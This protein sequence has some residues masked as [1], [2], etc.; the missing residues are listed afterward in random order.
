MRSFFAASTLA[1]LAGVA[2]AR[3][4]L[5]NEN[6]L[7]EVPPG[8]KIDFQQ[9][10][11]SGVMN[12]MV[13]TG[14]T[15]NDWTEMVTVQIFYNMKATPPQFLG[16]MASTWAAAC[17]GAST[18]A[19]ASGPE[20]GYPAGVS[21][22]N[23]PKNP[24]TGKPELTWIKAVQGNDSFYVVQKAFKFTPSKDEVVQWM[25]YLRSVAV[26]DSRLADRACP[27]TKD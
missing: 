23:C 25:K 24:A 27:Q 13:P 15:V 21:L 1:L 10:K 20:N 3:A 17:P 11:P 8:Y 26:C 7:V 9:K 14:E 16:K 6:L 4:E 5:V 19:I 18:T 2:V 12:E 22:L